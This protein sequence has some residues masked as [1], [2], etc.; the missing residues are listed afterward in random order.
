MVREKI[1]VGSLQSSSRFPAKVVETLSADRVITLDEIDR[2]QSFAFDPGGLGRNV[3]L[4]AEGECE[5][6]IVAISNEADAAEIITVRNDGG[7][8]ILTPTQNEAALLWCDG[9][10]W[11]GLVGA[12]A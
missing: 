9:V 11:Y 1:A 7:G 5:G 12:T 6:S 3:D 10:S 2:F 8:T 4:P